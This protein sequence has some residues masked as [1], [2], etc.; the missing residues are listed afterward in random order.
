MRTK[1]GSSAQ[2][3]PKDAL[4]TTPSDFPENSTTCTGLLKAYSKASGIMH[5]LL[6]NEIDG[7]RILNIYSVIPH[8]QQLDWVTRDGQKQA[9]C[10]QWPLVCRIMN[11]TTTK[12]GFIRTPFSLIV[13]AK[14]VRLDYEPPSRPISEYYSY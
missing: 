9:L 13:Q 8:Q 10:C 2:M 4:K 6:W 7:V 12:R 11:Q 14:H 3:M 5:C 1:L